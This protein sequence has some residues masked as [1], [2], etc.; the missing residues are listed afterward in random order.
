MNKDPLIFIRHMVESM[1]FIESFSKGLT[2]EHLA[3]DELKQSAIIRKIEIVGEAAKNLPKEYISKHP[4]IPWKDIIGMRDKIIHHYFDID[5]DIVWQVITVDLP[6]VKKKL[7]QI[8]R[9][10]RPL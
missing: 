3:Q 6:D 8:L 7:N 9:D 5:L 2:K 1:T 10:S 4:S